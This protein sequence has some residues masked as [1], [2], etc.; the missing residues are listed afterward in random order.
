M[1][2][3]R[4]MLCEE[5]FDDIHGFSHSYMHIFNRIDS[6]FDCFYFP[7]VFS[8]IHFE[9]NKC[10][11]NF[12]FLRKKNS[13]QSQKLPNWILIFSVHRYSFFFY[14]ASSFCYSLW[15]IAQFLFCHEF[16]T[17]FFCSLNK[18]SRIEQF[19]WFIYS[20]FQL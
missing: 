13:L 9:S 17:V 7:F 10:Q 15:L 12:V 8:S 19:R 14:L 6:L 1:K 18:I 2:V 5:I 20:H 3:N 11:H 4:F 16:S